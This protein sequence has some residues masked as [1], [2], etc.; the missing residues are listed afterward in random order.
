MAIRCFSVAAFAVLAAG[1]G[2]K[3]KVASHLRASLR[4]TYD[5]SS[6]NDEVAASRTLSTLDANR[7]GRVDPLEIANFAK[8]QGLDAD[9]V[10]AEFGGLDTNGDGVLD[11]SELASALSGD[12]AVAPAQPAEAQPAQMVSAPTATRLD[13]ETP[14]KA[15]QLDSTVAMQQDTTGEQS[16][17]TV[18]ESIVAELSAQEG[19]EREAQSLERLAAEL[20]ANSTA[21]ARR[22]IQKAVE[23]GSEA[24]MA[25][26]QE[27]L[28]SLTSMQKSA[29]DA[30]V[31]SAM[32]HAKAQAEMMQADVLMGVANQALGAQDNAAAVKSSAQM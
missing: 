26:A 22:T 15:T 9:S 5:A 32:L 18:A 7:D 25:K 4:G 10:A 24:A 23:A 11:Q 30:E 27:I 28:K 6:P 16:A 12:Q 31:Q 17:Q 3:S 1:A 8:A 14:E 2:T 20:K 21:L 19:A 29:S 13:P